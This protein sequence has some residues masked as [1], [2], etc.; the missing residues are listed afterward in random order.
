MAA[1]TW[2]GN[3][4]AGVGADDYWISGG[5][6]RVSEIRGHVFPAGV[7]RPAVR[8]TETDAVSDA[9]GPGSFVLVRQIK[10]VR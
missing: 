7:R 5:E 9:A 2:S 1:A 10:F 3:S 6:N 4:E 8:Q